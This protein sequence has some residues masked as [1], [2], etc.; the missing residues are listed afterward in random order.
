MRL[1]GYIIL[2]AIFFLVSALAVLNAQDVAFN[3][4]LGSF[5]LP[6][7][8]LLLIGFVLGLVVGMLLAFISRGKKRN[9][10]FGGA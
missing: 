3:Y 9:N 4:L 2:L 5:N 7:I 8:L 1:F 10:K 6:L